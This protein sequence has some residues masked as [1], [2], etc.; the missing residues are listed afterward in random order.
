MLPLMPDEGATALTL[1]E[2]LRAKK[3]GKSKN[4]DPENLDDNSG[5]RESV[6]QLPERSKKMIGPWGY[7]LREGRPFKQHQQER[8]FR[9]HHHF[10]ES[11]C[12][13]IYGKTTNAQAEQ[14]YI[15]FDGLRS[16]KARRC[17]MG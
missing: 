17:S 13:S 8:A 14:D 9:R 11:T 1:P 16:T 10:Q 4:L 7:K 12:T 5:P 6:F 3:K 15:A 2:E